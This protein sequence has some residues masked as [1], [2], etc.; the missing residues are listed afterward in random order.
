[1]A[2]VMFFTERWLNVMDH[3]GVH[4]KSEQ[5]GRKPRKRISG[6]ESPSAKERLGPIVEAPAKQGIFERGRVR[7]VHTQGSGQAEPG[8]AKRG[9]L[10]R[11]L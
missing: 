10:K 2:A 4:A 9:W 3:Y 5:P 1:M 6:K 7:E 11:W 8:G